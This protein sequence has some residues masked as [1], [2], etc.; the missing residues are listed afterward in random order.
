MPTQSKKRHRW[1]GELGKVPTLAEVYE[2]PRNHLRK[3]VGR[4]AVHYG[5]EDVEPLEWRLV[6]LVAA[7]AGDAR[8]PAFQIPLQ[9]KAGRKTAWTPELRRALVNAED[10]LTRKKPHLS[11]AKIFR[12]LALGKMWRGWTAQSLKKQSDLARK[13]T[14]QPRR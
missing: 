9:Q 8:V 12:E 14:A 5:L 7:M 4:L 10:A 2:S 3:N 1:T 6:R 13:A 11:R